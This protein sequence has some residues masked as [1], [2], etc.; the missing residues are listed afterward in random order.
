[1]HGHVGELSLLQGLTNEKVFLT[2]SLRE[3]QKSEAV[4]V[5]A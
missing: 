5:Q 3:A 1:M 4:I 2:V